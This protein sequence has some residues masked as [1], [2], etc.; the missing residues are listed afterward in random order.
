LGFNAGL[1]P[2]SSMLSANELFTPAEDWLFSDD[3]DLGLAPWQWLDLIAEVLQRRLPSLVS[4][5][6]AIPP[7]LSVSGAVVFGE[8][9]QLPAFGSITGPAY[10]GAGCELRPGV[11]IRGNLIAGRGCVLGNSCEFK[12]ALL[13]DGVQVPHFSYVGDSILG[14]HAHLGAGVI[15]SNLR[16]DQTTVMVKLLNGQRVSTNRRKVGALIGDRAEVGCNAVLN[17]GVILHPGAVVGPSLAFTGSLERD[18]L[19]LEK[20]S[21]HRMLRPDLG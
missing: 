9:V 8:G 5:P 17:P 3:F 21:Q 2:M 20:P 19:V 11:Y 12:N 14:N 1:S 16:L 13:L 4:V 6:V 15:C 10:I 18:Q 7:G